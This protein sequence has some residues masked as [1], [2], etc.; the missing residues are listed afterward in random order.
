M[1]PGRVHLCCAPVTGGG[2]LASACPTWDHSRGTVVS[3]PCSSEGQ[4]VEGALPNP[5]FGPKAKRTKQNRAIVQAT[6]CVRSLGSEETRAELAGDT[7]TQPAHRESG[8]PRMR[9]E[10]QLVSARRLEGAR[11]CPRPPDH[12]PTPGP[13]QEHPKV[14][15]ELPA[16]HSKGMAMSHRKPPTIPSVGP[17]LAQ[18]SRLPSGVYWSGFLPGPPGLLVAGQ[19]PSL[20]PHG[21]EWRV[22]SRAAKAHSRPSDPLLA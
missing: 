17:C 2:T 6:L 14:G 15:F 20:E 10:T 9:A 16:G 4:W 19:V 5:H 12:T 3:G 1:A 22:P 8:K 11:P 7:G 21:A 13:S 18:G